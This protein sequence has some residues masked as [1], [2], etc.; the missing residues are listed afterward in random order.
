MK[1]T[2]SPILWWRAG[3]LYLALADERSQLQLGKTAVGVRIFF[4]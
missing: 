3:S 4:M 1:K 2:R